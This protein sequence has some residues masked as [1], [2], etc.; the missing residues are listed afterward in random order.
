MLSFQFKMYRVLF[1]KNKFNTFWH[2]IVEDLINELNQIIIIFNFKMQNYTFI[3]NVEE[4]YLNLS[5]H[6]YFSCLW[7]FTF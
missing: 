3:H 2:Q 7:S 6:L 5:E 1:A 4:E